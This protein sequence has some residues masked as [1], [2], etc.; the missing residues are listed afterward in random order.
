M[1]DDAIAKH[2]DVNFS[3]MEGNG[4]KIFSHIELRAIAS[5]VRFSNSVEAG[6]SI[7]GLEYRRYAHIDRDVNAVCHSITINVS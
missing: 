2:C 1:T 3:Q 4:R 7:P 5:S 6:S